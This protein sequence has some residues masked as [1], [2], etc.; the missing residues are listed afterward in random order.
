M[1][2][3][4]VT[5][6]RGLV[7]QALTHHLAEAPGKLLAI[8]ATSDE[9]SGAEG[10]ETCRVDCRSTEF[11]DIVA[12][13]LGG[14]PRFEL[15]H[16]AGSVPEP[17]HIT[18][19]DVDDFRAV[20]DDNLA[21]AYAA[22]RTTARIARKS[23]ISGSL[24][25]LGSVGATRAHRY[26]AAYDAAKAGVEALVRSF[27]V[28]YGAYGISSRL[29]AVGP[30]AESASTAQDGAY[31]EALVRLVPLQRYARVAEIATAVATFGGA[32]FD[33]ANGHTITLDGG[34]SQQLRPLD[35][36]RPPDASV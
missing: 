22:M 20:I 3:R 17:T 24:T 27:A 26:K 29:V 36:E 28:E 13:F 12:D 31:A 32:A 15:F 18:D 19:I 25:V 9:V 34:L 35:I 14:A 10:I 30:I 33:M 2:H 6:A 16:T 11:S 23:E 7:G 4:I 1:T 8:D 5:G 21:S